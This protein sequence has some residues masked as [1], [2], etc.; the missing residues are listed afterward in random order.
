MN[1]MKMKFQAIF[2]IVKNIS[3]HNG[4]IHVHQAPFSEDT[5]SN[6]KDKEKTVN[7]SNGIHVWSWTVPSLFIYDFTKCLS[8]QTM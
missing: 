1:K 4:N 8:E 2:A 6:K 7:L 3:V 5:V